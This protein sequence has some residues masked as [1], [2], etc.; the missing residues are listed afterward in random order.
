MVS[1]RSFFL[2]SGRECLILSASV[3]SRDLAVRTRGFMFAEAVFM[4]AAHDI[5]VAMH[6]SIKKRRDL[7]REYLERYRAVLIN[8]NP[9]KQA[10]AWLE[11]VCYLRDSAVVQ[12]A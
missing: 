9:D 10:V 2:L 12:K 1:I 4:Q 3:L 11:E 7:R 5:A 8:A 6:H